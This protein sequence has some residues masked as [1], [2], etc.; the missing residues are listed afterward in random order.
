MKMNVEFELEDK[1]GK[2]SG[3][4]V[5][6]FEVPGKIA[7]WLEDESKGE[8][9]GTQEG[10][11]IG[12]KITSAHN[13]KSFFYIPACARMTDDLRARLYGSELV[14]FDGT[15]WVND[16]MA[17]SKV[18]EKT[19]QRMGHMNN[20]GPDGTMAEFEDIDVTRKIFIHIN[21]TNPILLKNSEERKEV[22]SKG[23]EVSYDGMEIEL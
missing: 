21:T 18:G 4:L 14:L 23:W 3:I 7:L 13:K 9:F 20:S 11:T 19:G 17:S 6:A 16:E 1:N 8:N 22:E 10:D 12:L 15:L 2:L 5:E